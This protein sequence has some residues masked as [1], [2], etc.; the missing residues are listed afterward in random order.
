MAKQ[1]GINTHVFINGYDFSNYFKSFKGGASVDALDATA[2]QDTAK[3]YLVSAF[4][5]G[6]MDLEGFYASDQA[7]ADQI[8]DILRPKLG[9]E[10]KNVVTVAPISANTLGNYCFMASADLLNLNVDDIADG[11]VMET[12][13]FQSSSGLESGVILQV[14]TSLTATGNGSSVDNTAATTNG[15][16]GHL[17]VFS[18]SGTSPTLD[19]KIQHSTDNSTWVDLITFTQAT[20]ITSE[21][22]TVAAGT[23]V[24][25]YLRAIRTIGG[26][27]TPTFSVA[28]SFARH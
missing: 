5:M 10:T 24:R 19:V 22:I 20:D 7:T 25:R 6:K 28:V 12:A 23:T 14:K 4:Q 21:R 8:D 27:S 2:F 17:H 16:A 15:G 9:N 1:R 11:L 13:N 18:K 3:A 26:T